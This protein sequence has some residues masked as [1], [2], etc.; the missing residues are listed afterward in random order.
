MILAV[1]ALFTYWVPN[2]PKLSFPIRTL[3]EY[4]F[5]LGEISRYIALHESSRF[6][7]ARFMHFNWVIEVL[8]DNLICRRRSYALQFLKSKIPKRLSLFRIVT[9]YRRLSTFMSKER[10]VWLMMWPPSKNVY[11]AAETWEEERQYARR[12]SAWTFNSFLFQEAIQVCGDPLS[13]RDQ[14]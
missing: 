14:H 11:G 5:L 7:G 2:A 6:S 8:T 1:S 4:I 10:C 3:L 13:L 12:S 9:K